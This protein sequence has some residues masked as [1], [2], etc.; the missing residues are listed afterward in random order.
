MV[1]V[2][3]R[4]VV[5]PCSN[6]HLEIEP[7]VTRMLERKGALKEIEMRTMKNPNI[8]TVIFDDYALCA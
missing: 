8:S 6:G 4:A 5:K 2:S 7:N 3:S 1:S